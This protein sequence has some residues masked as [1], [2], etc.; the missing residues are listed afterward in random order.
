MISMHGYENIQG[1]LQTHAK[2]NIGIL[3]I[4]CFYLFISSDAIGFSYNWLRWEVIDSSVVYQLQ[5]DSFLA[6]V[7]KFLLHLNAKLAT[8]CNYSAIKTLQAIN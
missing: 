5:G 3:C 8:A 4:I 1:Y 7:S 6:N 2:T